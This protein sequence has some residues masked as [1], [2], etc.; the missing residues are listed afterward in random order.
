MTEQPKAGRALTEIIMSG[1]KSPTMK[2]KFSGNTKPF[3]YPNSPTIA[4]YSITCTVDPAVEKEFVKSIK[5]IEVSER[6]P[7]SPLKTDANKEGQTY[8]QTGLIQIKFMAS[9]PIPV[10]ADEA[11]T[12]PITDELDRG[13]ELV[14]IFDISRYTHKES[15]AAGLSFKPVK[16]IAKA[17]VAAEAPA[18]NPSEQECP[19]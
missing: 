16:A 14:M 15:G 6:C 7:T 5:A 13:S 11:C 1:M 10:F 3:Y 17:A 12:Q 8:I 19:F 4:R 18:S 2:V 9:K